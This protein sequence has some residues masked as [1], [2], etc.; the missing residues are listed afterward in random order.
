MP[1]LSR[2]RKNASIIERLRYRSCAGG[3]RGLQLGQ[4]R[5]QILRSPPD[6]ATLVLDGQ[7]S[8]SPAYSTAPRAAPQRLQ[9]KMIGPGPCELSNPQ[10]GAPK[11]R[12]QTRRNHRRSRQGSSEIT[13]SVTALKPRAAQLLLQMLV[14]ILTI[15][16]VLEQRSRR[17][18]S[19]ASLMKISYLSG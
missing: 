1:M 6:S 10:A 4:H 5:K 14:E 3:A 9:R 12:H 2:R 16:A 17:R 18:S 7:P 8:P 13:R 19:L 11:R 15:W